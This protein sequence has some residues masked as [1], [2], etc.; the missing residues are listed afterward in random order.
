MNITYCHSAKRTCQFQLGHR[1]LRGMN[2]KWPRTWLS[3]VGWTSWTSGLKLEEN[4]ERETWTNHDLKSNSGWKTFWRT[5]AMREPPG[6]KTGC[7]PTPFHPQ[8]RQPTT[9]STLQH[10]SGEAPAKFQTSQHPQWRR[11]MRF[12]K[13]STEGWTRNDLVAHDVGSPKKRCWMN[14]KKK[15]LKNNQNVRTHLPLSLRA[16]TSQE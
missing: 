10:H 8:K 14:S 7:A 16:N 5:T 15:Y 11:N 2:Q 1:D 6:N 4:A 3:D 9:H 13:T 12:L